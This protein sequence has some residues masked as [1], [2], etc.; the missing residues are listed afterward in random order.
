M[1]NRSEGREDR[2]GREELEE[3]EE[4]NVR[5]SGSREVQDPDPAPEVGT[6]EAQHPTPA[7][8]RTLLRQRRIFNIERTVLG[9]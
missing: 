2:E 8:G 5:D 1:S 4:R 7:R 6:G 9:Y 3:L